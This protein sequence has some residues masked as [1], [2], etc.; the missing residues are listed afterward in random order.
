MRTF[1]FSYNVKARHNWFTLVSNNPHKTAQ[2]ITD[3]LPEMACDLAANCNFLFGFFSCNL[4]ED[5]IDIKLMVYTLWRINT[6]KKDQ[7]TQV[8]RCVPWGTEVKPFPSLWRKMM[9]YLKQKQTIATPFANRSYQSTPERSH[10]I[11]TQSRPK[12]SPMRKCRHSTPR[13]VNI[14]FHPCC[15]QR[16]WFA[17]IKAKEAEA[18]GKA[19]TSAQ[20]AEAP[21]N[22]SLKPP[23]YWA[24]CIPKGILCPIK[25]PIKADWP[26]NSEEEKECQE[27][28]KDKDTFSDIEDWD[29]DLEEWK[30]EQIKTMIIRPPVK[31]EIHIYIWN[32]YYSALQTLYRQV[33]QADQCAF[34]GRTGRRN[35]WRFC[36]RHQIRSTHKKQCL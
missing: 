24:I 27:Q 21:A 15:M 13:R 18:K 3:I 22:P 16:N 34:R 28:S 11:T 8:I 6:F 31:P 25:Y 36:R 29:G 23:E 9:E 4:L 17:M 10:A 32:S 30:W 5:T 20:P 26:D 2:D 1:A 35:S 12:A 7:N 33:W 19:P 14:G